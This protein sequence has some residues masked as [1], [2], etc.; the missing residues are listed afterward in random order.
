LQKGIIKMENHN[1]AKTDVFNQDD[2]LFNDESKKAPSKEL[3]QKVLIAVVAL[4]VLVFLVMS[5]C[6]KKQVAATVSATT[7]AVDSKAQDSIDTYEAQLNE[8]K[9][10]NAAKTEEWSK[11][12]AD[13]QPGQ[14]NVPI[15]NR[16]AFGSS[17][18]QSVTADGKVISGNQNSRYSS[19]NASS[20]Y[21]APVASTP[22]QPYKYN[23]PTAMKKRL[24]PEYGNIV[25][26]FRKS[27][28]EAKWVIG[29][30]E[31]KEM[32][33][34]KGNLMNGV[35]KPLKDLYDNAG[36]VSSILNTRIPAGSRI[37][38]TLDQDV[39][40]DHPGIFTATVIRPFEVKGYKLICQSGTN[41]RDRIN[42]TVQKII[43]TSNKE[44]SLE[45]QVQNG[46]PGLTGRI[47]NHVMKRVG[48]ALV[49]AAI[50]GGF[51]AWSLKGGD[52]GRIDTR[53]AIVSGVVE[54][55]VSGVQNEVT[56]LGGDF[57]NTVLVKQ[58][59]QFEIL[60]TSEVVV[61]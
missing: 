7:D 42:V 36:T 15:D 17:N 49:N 9:S 22:P 39:S 46:Y 57:P 23:P 18:N 5:N 21:D 55:S 32:T 45:G 24:D 59:T 33:S 51:L 35:D 34:G 2:K 58:G 56:R 4:L 54:Q 10:K 20:Q 8:Y 61:Q 47:K 44:F 60:I 16:P 52:Q 13:Q 43:S 53:D 12:E 41:Q 6:N 37:I 27:R 1:K 31:Y 30:G 50:G 38:A 48:P 25:E 29:D 3:L 26:H 40:S 11:S 28:D 14:M 19:P